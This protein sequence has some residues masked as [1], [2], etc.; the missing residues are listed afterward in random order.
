MEHKNSAGLFVGGISLIIA[1]PLVVFVAVAF[2]TRMAFDNGATGLD[3]PYLV[4][5]S[6]GGLLGLVGI[7]LLVGATYRALVKIDSMA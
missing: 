5:A 2:G 4:A 1:S 3:L 6:V 7:I